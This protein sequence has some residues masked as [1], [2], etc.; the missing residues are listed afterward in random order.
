MA[1]VTAPLIAWKTGGRFYT[2]R[3][4]VPLATDHQLVGCS[5][6]EHRFEPEDVTHCPAYDGA[7][8]SLCCSLDA[9]CED[10]CKP[11]AGYQEQM[12]QFLG[13][14]LPAPLLSALRSR[15]GHFLSLL[16]VIN[17]FSALLLSLIYFKTPVTSLAEATP[18]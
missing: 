15:L 16:V 2:A 14:F 8:C 4:F 17:G 5:I 11:G 13:R 10:A 9:R 3:P 12:Q 7:I 6:C 18:S 1:L